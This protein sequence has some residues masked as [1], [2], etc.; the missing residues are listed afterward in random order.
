[1]LDVSTYGGGVDISF[2][3]LTN[4]TLHDAHMFPGA[5]QTRK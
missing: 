4:I 5:D 2:N 1:M 3:I